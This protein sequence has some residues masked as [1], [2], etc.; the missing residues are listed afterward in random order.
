MDVSLSHL[1]TSTLRQVSRL[2]KL[3]KMKPTTVKETKI[4]NHIDFFLI[5]CVVPVLTAKY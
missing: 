3:F 2:E 1:Y 5:T 4:L